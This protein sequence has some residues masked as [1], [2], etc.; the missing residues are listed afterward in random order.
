MPDPTLQD[1]VEVVAHL[2]NLQIGRD[3]AER[4]ALLD[5]L[6][7]PSGNAAPDGVKPLTPEEQDALASLQAR[8]DAAGVASGPNN[9]AQAQP[10]DAD[11]A[12]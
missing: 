11:T 4:A 6:G 9:A 7:N 10:A 8:A 2:V 12:G 3:E 1:V 5:K